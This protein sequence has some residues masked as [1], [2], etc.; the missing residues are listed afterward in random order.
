MYTLYCKMCGNEM[1]AVSPHRKY[2]DLCQKKRNN[3]RPKDF[4]IEEKFK[5]RTGWDDIMDNFKARRTTK[6][7]EEVYRIA[8]LPITDP[9]FDTDTLTESIKY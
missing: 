4:D 5:M 6:Q 7:L 2:C 3:T 8:S 9:M 1:V